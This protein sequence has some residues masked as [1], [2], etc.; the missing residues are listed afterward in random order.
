MYE[1]FIVDTTLIFL[2]VFEN[3]VHVNVPFVFGVDDGRIQLVVFEFDLL[4]DTSISE[5]KSAQ[6][7]LM[8]SQQSSFNDLL[9]LE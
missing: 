6:S 2:K 7:K 3:I 9:S 8:F 4:F 1:T 5:A